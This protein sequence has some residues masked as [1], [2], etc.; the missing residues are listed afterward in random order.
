MGK[1]A[2]LS[3]LFSLLKKLNGTVLILIIYVIAVSLLKPSFL[4]LSNL[5]NLVRSVSIVGIMACAITLV[6]LTSNTELS[7]GSILSFCACISCTFVDTNPFLSVAAPII[8]GACCGLVNGFL[9]GKVKINSFVTTL[10]M[11]YV[12]QALAL[13]YTGSRY[14]ITKNEDGWYKFL[15]NG[16]VFGIPMPVIVFAAVAL[17][18][19]F[20]Q[21][22]TIF[23]S[24]IYAVGSNATS[25]RFSGINVSNTIMLTY[26]FGGTAIGISSIIMCSRVMSAQPYMGSGYEF[27]VLT[28]VVLGGLNVAGGKGTVA[29]TVLGVIFVGVL[30]NSFTL[31]GIPANLSYVG[32]GVVLV[33][34]VAN[35]I[36]KERRSNRVKKRKAISQ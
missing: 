25:A 27:E 12:Y 36:T 20:V 16:Y 19:I 18:V 4:S 22:K 15:G 1:T 10:G 9:V 30:K 34:A 11:S 14:L 33:I 35:Q 21:K 31:L 2:L 29:G 5:T 26:V 6:M 17:C 23:G 13:L 28:A 32:L 3:K 8:A 7:A 24:H